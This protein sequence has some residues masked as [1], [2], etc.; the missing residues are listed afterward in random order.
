M[1]IEYQNLLFEDRGGII[2]LTINRPAALNALNSHVFAELLQYFTI[3]APAI[4][5]LKGVVI[6]GSGDRAFVAGA[7][8]TEFTGLE[9]G[10]ATL[11]LKQGNE[12]MNRIETFSKPVV[13]VINGFALGGGC[14][15]AMA[16]HFR[17]ASERAKFGLP[18]INLGILPGYGGSQRL[19]QLIGKARALE[20]MLTGDMITAQQALQFGLINQIA[21]LGQELEQAINL[22][23]KISSKPPMSVTR[24]ISAVNSYYPSLHEGIHE[25]GKHF[26]DLAQTEDF[27][28]GVRAFLEKRKPV[29]TGK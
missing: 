9:P 16:C 28:E 5:G 12:V 18:E 2:I 22:L 20:M 21:E 25:E 7:D 23:T 29:F 13:A 19:P 15:L 1:I 17:I 10:K 3:D 26:N 27:K 11:F 24:I 4:R 14:E 8:I 6:Q